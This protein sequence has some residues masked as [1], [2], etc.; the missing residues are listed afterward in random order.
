MGT[1]DITNEIAVENER[2]KREELQIELLNFAEAKI[3]R[4]PRGITNTTLTPARIQI[5]GW[6]N[7]TSPL[8]ESDVDSEYYNRVAERLVRV[9]KQALEL[10]TAAES[11]LNAWEHSKDT[12]TAHAKAQFRNA[13][14][15]LYDAILP[16]K[17]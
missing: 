14:S 15:E 11:V 17:E 9:A 16:T 2:L 7:F 10:K 4:L 8:P 12:P 6:I 1:R 13:I 5:D 3:E